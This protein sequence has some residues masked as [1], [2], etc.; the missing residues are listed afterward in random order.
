[1]ALAYAV[2]QLNTG[3]AVKFTVILLGSLVASVLVYEAV[4]RRLPVAR[5]LFGM[6]P[7]RRTAAR[8]A[9][10]QGALPAP[11]ETGAAS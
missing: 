10:P 6:K 7:L 2:V 4:V 11:A 9:T 1:M 3:V 5:F 8:Q